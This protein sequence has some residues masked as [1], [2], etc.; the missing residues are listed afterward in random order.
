MQ[1]SM[2][3]HLS[4]TGLAGD[5]RWRAV[6]WTRNGSNRAHVLAHVDGSMT[7]LLRHSLPH[8]TEAERHLMVLIHDHHLVQ[9]PSYRAQLSS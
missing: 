5:A 2:V 9:S 7:K 3:L 1:W 6:V 8:V 4:L